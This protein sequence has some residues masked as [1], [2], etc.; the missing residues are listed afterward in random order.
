M[1][2]VANKYALLYR[3]IYFFN[4]KKAD[5]AIMFIINNNKLDL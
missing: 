4:I 2:K 5:C 1:S 3:N